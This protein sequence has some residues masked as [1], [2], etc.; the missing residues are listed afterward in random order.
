MSWALWK[1][2][3]TGEYYHHKKIMDISLCRLS[4]EHLCTQDSGW[5]WIRQITHNRSASNYWKNKT[6]LY[7]AER[8]FRSCFL[9]WYI[10]ADHL[11]KL[12]RLLN[13]IAVLKDMTPRARD[14]LVSF[15]ECMSTR[16]FAAYLNKIGVK[17][18]QV[19]GSILYLYLKTPLYPHISVLCCNKL[20]K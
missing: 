18:R 10:F 7:D 14:Y 12:E 11:E 9:I 16:I 5:A 2:C 3:T 17:A 20:I 1:N 6:F 15:G 19:C 8:F 4:V 13:G